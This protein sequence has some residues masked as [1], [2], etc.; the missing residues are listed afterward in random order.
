[1]DI[2][3]SGNASTNYTEANFHGATYLQGLMGAPDSGF[4]VGVDSLMS[5]GSWLV[6]RTPVAPVLAFDI[7]EPTPLTLVGIGLLVAGSRARRVA[8]DS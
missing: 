4:N 6:S 8:R 1:V 5:Y 7:P 3:A 2:A